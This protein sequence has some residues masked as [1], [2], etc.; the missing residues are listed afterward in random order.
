MLVRRLGDDL[1]YTVTRQHSDLT[2][3][4]D[5]DFTE[6]LRKDIIEFLKEDQTVL[7]IQ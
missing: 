1:L 2:Q 6:P 7:E 3:S 4:F 5:L